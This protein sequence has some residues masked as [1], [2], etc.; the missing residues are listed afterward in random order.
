MIKTS[1]EY[2]YFVEKNELGYESFLSY[3]MFL[4]EFTAD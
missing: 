2:L 3:W 4:A 1:A